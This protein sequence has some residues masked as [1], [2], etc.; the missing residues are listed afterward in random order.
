MRK[1]TA[2]VKKQA[3]LNSFYPACKV[4]ET[5]TGIPALVTLAQAAIESA[6]GSKA[7]GNNYFGIKADAGW[8][9]DKRAVTTT[10]YH[11]TAK[12][13]YPKI[14]SIVPEGVKYK[15]TVVDYFRVY[16]TVED[17]F[18]DHGKF[19]KANPRYSNAFKETDPCEFAKAIAK[20]G[21]ATA[22]NYADSIC[23]LIEDFKA[24]LAMLKK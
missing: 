11:D 4:S 6:W 21:Y 1:V 24:I 15:Y 7:P 17:S 18:E 23:S 14:L 9:G 13:K 22:P 10:E 19:L 2:L 3:F 16:N 5:A 12:V 20:A 8:T